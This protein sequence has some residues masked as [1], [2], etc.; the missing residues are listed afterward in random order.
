MQDS[1]GSR[2]RY[3]REA[4]GLSISELSAQVR[5]REVLL[6]HI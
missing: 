5:V 3:A 6:K 2:L 4:K 1:V